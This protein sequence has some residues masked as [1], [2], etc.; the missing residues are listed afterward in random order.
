M[1]I[2]GSA[3]SGRTTVAKKVVEEL[4]DQGAKVYAIFSIPSLTAVPF[5]GV[6]SLGLDLRSRAVGILGVSDLLSEHLARPGRR[7]L[8]VDDVETLD[9]ESLSVIDI[10][11]RRTEVPV[12]VTA[13]DAPLR[14][15]LPAH[16]VAR[17]PQATVALPPLRYEQVNLLIAQLLGA[18]ADV[19]VAARVLTKS[20]GNLRLAVRIIE[21]AVLSEQLVLRDGQWRMNGPTLFNEH[22][23]AT[24]EAMLQGLKPEEFRALGTMAVLGPAVVDRLASVAGAEVLD[25]LEH[26]GLVSVVP[27]PDGTLL[28][29]VFPPLIEEYLKGHIASS[30]RI[31]R[32]VITDEFAV[33]ASEHEDAAAAGVG[34][35]AVA[36][37]LAALRAE[38]KGNQVA[39]SRYF[40]RRLDALEQFHY[41]VWELDRSMANAVAFLRVYWGAPI[42]PHRVQEVFTKTSSVGCDPADL[43]FFTMTRALWLVMND[44]ELDDAKEMVRKAAESEPT[45]SGEAEAI[46]LFLDAT[47]HAVP[48]D[49]DEIFARLEGLHPKSGLVAAVRGAIEL[50]R[51][52]PEA[53]LRA[54]DSAEGFETL[55]RF[56]QFVRGMALF[57]SG[58][59]D[60]AL[61]FALDRRRDALRSVDQFSLIANSYVAALALLYRGR[62]DEAEYL[63]GW[64]FS[65][66]RPGFLVGA[67]YN[68]ML[69]L[70]SL[71]TCGVAALGSQAG[72]GAAVP[73]V[74]PFPGTG[75]G[76]YELVTR[77]PNTLDSFDES[78][79]RLIDAALD[80]GYVTEAVMTGIFTL[81]LLP[82]PGIKRR[83]E[84]LLA[85][86]HNTQHDQLLAVAGA[87]LAGDTKGL[88]AILDDYQPDEDVYQ[89]SM[90]LRG[91]ARRSRILG[92]SP[93]AS[94]IERAANAFAR[95]LRPGGQ[96]I[97]FE[98]E[99][100]ASALTARETEIALMAGQKSNQEIAEQFGLSIRTVESHI[101][102]A[103]RKTSTTTRRALFELVRDMV[104]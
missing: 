11:Q 86:F 36:A 30:R 67:L 12:I 89:T 28:G 54:L 38:L 16:A 58:R 97:V 95:R 73:D 84:R 8:V 26:R 27:G 64:A 40:H 96:Y 70:S 80:L 93:T 15:A 3:G 24:V 102:N 45:W 9:R 48:G 60:E 59:V 56:E 98:P 104:S 31:F 37:S 33:A 17:W 10:V 18:P 42:D 41:R 46:A 22:L 65:L 19:D 63:M 77:R 82:T 1:R 88:V 69:R 76:L 91:A 23:H 47:Y 90:L 85:D 68:A 39:M 61:V 52:D 94:A 78:A 100:A 99:V 25:A 71:R 81:C 44:G 20:G 79:T 14:V 35:G 66:R 32:S 51:F 29:S 7:V 21:T 55:P 2:V 5:A 6:L 74:D 34:D 62:Y 72:T 49:I 57:V 83:V 92:D 13:S 43:L 87:A 75:K 50:Y 53:A 103:L 4:E 101:S